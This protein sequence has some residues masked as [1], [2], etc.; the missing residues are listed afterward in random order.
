LP[1]EVT[2]VSIS[3]KSR[4]WLWEEETARDGSRGCLEPETEMGSRSRASSGRKPWSARTR[5]IDAMSC[6]FRLV[7][8]CWRR[9]SSSVTLH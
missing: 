7:W 5:K 1:W 2:D 6:P 4:R 9:T 3:S 8:S